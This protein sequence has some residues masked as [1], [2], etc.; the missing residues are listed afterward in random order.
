MKSVHGKN[1]EISGQYSFW[2]PIKNNI[3][4][5]WNWNCCTFFV[6][7]SS[8]GAMAPLAL[9]SGDAS[10]VCKMFFYKD[11]ETMQYVKS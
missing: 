3:S 9:P 4:E 7:K 1:C 2:T 11:T 8:G 5:V 6:R 10:K